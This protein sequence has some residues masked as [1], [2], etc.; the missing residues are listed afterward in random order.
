ML[1]CMALLALLLAGASF[2]AYQSAQQRV[3]TERVQERT[4]AILDAS[5]RLKVEML[6]SVRGERGYVITG[7]ERFLEP[8]IQAHPVLRQEVARLKELSDPVPEQHARARSIE[9]LLTSFMAWQSRVVIFQRQGDGAA[10]SAMIAD[11]DGRRAVD[12]ILDELAHVE[13]HANDALSESAVRAAALAQRNEIYQYGLAVVGCLLLLVS[14]LTTI[15]LRRAARAEQRVRDELHRRAMTD[16]LTGL[17]NRRELLAS[18]D[19]AIAAARRNRRPL[20]LALIDID[21]FKRIN[22][23]HG[24]PAGDAVIRR[25]AMLAVD[26]MR[27]QDTV[28]RLGGEEFAVV[29]PDCSAEDALFA[30]ER[31]RIAVRSTDLEMETGEEVYITLSTGVA[32][33]ER[34]DTGESMIARADAALY[35]AK[36]GGRDQVKLAA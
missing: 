30:C 7:D 16:D 8:Y 14:L 11:G 15:A 9:R 24:H 21:H 22:D 5:A 27:G 25:I 32:V 33:F 26:V 36:N 18:L 4:R 31:L 10:A 28:G 19:R 13:V 23:R 34:D 35:H 3:T 17:A 2:S 12:L 29:L 6:N 1:A 20:A